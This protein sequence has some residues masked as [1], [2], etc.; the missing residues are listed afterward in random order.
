MVRQSRKHRFNNMKQGRVHFLDEMRGFLIL[1]VV[2]YHFV[3]DLVLFGG[4]DGSWFFSAA[5]N[6]TRNLFVAMLIMISGVSSHFSHSNIRRGIKTFAVAMLLTV[7]T[8]FAMPDQLILFGIL[9]FFG[10]SMALYAL[11]KKPLSKIPPVWGFAVSVLL[12]CITFDVY[13]GVI[14]IAGWGLTLPLPSF[15]YNQPLLFPAGFMCAGL[16]SADYYPLLPWFF[17]FVAGGFCGDSIN[18]GR[19]PAFFYR[20]HCA[21]LATIGK[22]TLL[23][24]I[25]H[26]PIIYGIMLVCF[27]LL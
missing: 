7:V 19:F 25:L 27:N 3:Y 1:F 5:M 9:H 20:S 12:F 17:L 18:A 23:I 21:P 24:Y 14:G 4:M 16:T 10:V 26:Q 15:L 22:H 8:Y 6:N 2:G 13:Y 11:L